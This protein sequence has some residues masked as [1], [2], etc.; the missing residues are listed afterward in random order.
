MNKNSTSALS[1]AI[2]GELD[3]L[4]PKSIRMNRA[5]Q[6]LELAQARGMLAIL[7][8][9]I[10]LPLVVLL[11]YIFLQFGTG[12]DFSHDIIA[13]MTVEIVLISQHV[14]FQ[15][16]GNLRVTAAAYSL[17]YLFSITGV[18]LVSGGWDHSPLVILLIS[19]PLIAAMTMGTRAA[20]YHVVMVFIIITALLVMHLKHIPFPIDIS[21]AER[22]Q[23]TRF[24]CWGITLT[25][26]SIFLLFTDKLAHVKLESN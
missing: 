15:S 4:L 6:P 3:K 12:K 25:F 23:Y 14:Y 1:L 21:R 5:I 13:I 17:Q 10:L 9:S 8:I 24:I 18:I 26:I 2:V 19:S 16:Y 20:L 11:A 22:Y 7:I